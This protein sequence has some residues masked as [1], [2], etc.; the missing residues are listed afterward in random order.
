LSVCP[1]LV[2]TE[3]KRSSPIEHAL[4]HRNYSILLILYLHGADVNRRNVAGMTSL[5]VAACCGA[6]RAVHV[7]LQLG[8][9]V[10]LVT[11][12]GKTAEDLAQYAGHS[13]VVDAIQQSRK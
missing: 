3:I 10:T 7:M 1:A 12:S 2:N 9:D 6:V 13:A 8:A 5:H 4:R 11:S